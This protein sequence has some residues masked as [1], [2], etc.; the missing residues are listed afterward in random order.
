MHYVSLKYHVKLVNRIVSVLIRD[1]LEETFDWFKFV[2][3][4]P[5]P[6]ADLRNLKMALGPYEDPQNACPSR[7]G[8]AVL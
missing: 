4:C 2:C 8:R 7:D 6:S 3:K 5:A 1:K